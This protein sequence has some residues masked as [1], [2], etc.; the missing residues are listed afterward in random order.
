[1]PSAS[2][3]GHSQLGGRSATVLRRTNGKGASAEGWREHGASGSRQSAGG[4]CSPPGPA[5]NAAAVS[6]TIVFRAAVV[7]RGGDFFPRIVSVRQTAVCVS[8]TLRFAGRTRVRCARPAL[9]GDSEGRW[10]LIPLHVRSVR[11]TRIYIFAHYLGTMRR[12][13]S[14]GRSEAVKWLSGKSSSHGTPQN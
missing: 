5:G 9:S 6:R 11:R 8:G 14:G 4:R 1:V 10:L 12:P 13:A 2:R 7:T 3:P